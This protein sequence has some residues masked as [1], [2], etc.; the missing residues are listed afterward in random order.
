MQN[1]QNLQDEEQDTVVREHPL[2]NGR[3]ARRIPSRPVARGPVPRE[4]SCARGLG[5]GQALAL[6][7]GAAFFSAQR[8]GPRMP[9]AHPSGFPPRRGAIYETSHLI[10]T[11]TCEDG[12]YQRR[13]RNAA[14][15]DD[16]TDF[17]PFAAVSL[18]IAH[19]GDEGIDFHL[20]ARQVAN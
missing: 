11:K 3:M 1:L 16:A 14:R 18:L 19:V 12:E 15:G 5:E 6:H 8:G 2:P 9:R 20:Q 17:P 7:E 10:P 4:R 13:N